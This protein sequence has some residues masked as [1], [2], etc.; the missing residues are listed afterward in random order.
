MSKLAI[1]GGVPVRSKPFP[2]WPYFSEDEIGAVTRVLK[3]GKVNYWTGEEG[4]LFEKEFAESVGCNY[5]VTVANGSVALELA[6]MALGIGHGDEVV[7][8]PRTFIASAS[9]IV[10]RGA[11]PVFADVDLNS[12]NINAETINAVLTPKTKAIICVH[13]AGW[14]CDMGPIMDLAKKKGLFVIEDCAQAHGAKYRGR[15]VGSFGHIACF[16]F[17]QDKILTTGGEGGMLL[18]NDEAVFKKAWSYKDH[19]KSFD[20]VYP[21]LADSSKACWLHE[22]I[23]TNLRLTEMQSAIGRVVLKKLPHW[24]KLRRR[25]AEILEEGV[26]EYFA[27]RVAIPSE[28]V[29]NSYYRYSSYIRPERL[30]PGWDRDRI[31]AAINAE[32]I[33]SFSWNCSEVY[34]EKA[35]NN[36]QKL[37]V[38]SQKRLP[39]AKELGETS[40]IFLVHPTLAEEDMEDVLKAIDKVMR[41]TSHK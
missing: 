6:L 18:T 13:L 36:S 17:C 2:P 26:K 5:G 10:I 4:H 40:L 12:G 15:P 7:V 41:V 14:P 37:K 1:D 21:P 8:T 30:N 28:D 11:R 19:G 27:L 38:K 24:V 35:F 9:C 32:G 33:P 39:N 16:S 31:V 23:G 20:A 34:L 3:S 29:Y 22:S 25:N